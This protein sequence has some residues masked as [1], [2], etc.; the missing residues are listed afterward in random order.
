MF[1]ISNILLIFFLFLFI[2]GC[3]ASRK[4]ESNLNLVEMR[5]VKHEGSASAQ[6][7]ILTLENADTVRVTIKN[8]SGDPVAQEYVTVLNFGAYRLESTF[9]PLVPGAY[10]VDVRTSNDNFVRY[11]SVTDLR[12]NP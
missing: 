1:K 7:I 6:S 8:S 9:A 11:I 3:S 4:T 2:P 5:W 12:Q 10:F